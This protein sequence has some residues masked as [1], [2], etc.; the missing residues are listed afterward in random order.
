MLPKEFAFAL[1][2]NCFYSG[3]LKDGPAYKGKVYSSYHVPE[4]LKR[5]LKRAFKKPSKA[6][7]PLFQAQKLSKD[8]THT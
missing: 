4:A 2:Q 7:S 8:G 3:G 6:L 1:T 5:P